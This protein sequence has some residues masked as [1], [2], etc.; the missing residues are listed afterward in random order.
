LIVALTTLAGGCANVEFDLVQPPD[1]ETHVGPKTVTVWR[2]PLE[3][4]LTADE[5][6]LVMQI[7]NRSPQPITLWGGASTIVDPEGQSHPLSSR[8]IASQSF[9]KLILPPILPIRTAAPIGYPRG[10][11]GPEFPYN[12]DPYWDGPPD[13]P[14]PFFDSPPSPAY[15][16]QE[17]TYWRWD[18]GDVRVILVYMKGI[19]MPSLQSPPSAPA[20]HPAPAP[21]EAPPGSFTHEFVFRL[22]KM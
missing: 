5:A 22:R 6:H 12:G 2:P 8:V 18:H 10:F 20:T 13:Y 7:Y 17:F 19:T 15:N 1:L 9:I 4:Q 3:Y 21:I 14:D 16:D 11:F